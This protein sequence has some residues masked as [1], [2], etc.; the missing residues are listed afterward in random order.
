MSEAK[1]NIL[2]KAIVEFEEEVKKAKHD[3]SDNA[4]ALI[5]KAQSLSSELEKVAEATLDE[6]E[7]SI[8]GEKQA[9]IDALR[10]KFNEEKE[11]LLAQIRQRAEK[12]LEQAIEETI[13]ALEGAYK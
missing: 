9:T 13:K 3:T 11:S 10:K 8:E 1:L 5:L 4:K 6:A 7:K 12:N 2:T